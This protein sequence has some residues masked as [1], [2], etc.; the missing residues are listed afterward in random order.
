MNKIH[1]DTLPLNH[2]GK[3]EN[4]NCTSSV[5]RR[6]LD[7]GIVNGTKI[8]PILKSPSG[9]PTAFFIRGSTIAIRKEDAE[10]IEIII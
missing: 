4:I 1:L 10:F 2:T 5:K 6:L 8:T 3:V 7:L 9:D